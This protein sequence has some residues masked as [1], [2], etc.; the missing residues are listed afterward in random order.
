MD[1][2]HHWGEKQLWQTCECCGEDLSFRARFPMIKRE[3]RTVSGRSSPWS[4]VIMGQ[5]ALMVLFFTWPPVTLTYSGWAGGPPCSSSD[6]IN[7]S[8]PHPLTV[9]NHK[10]SEADAQYLLDILHLHRCRTQSIYDKLLFLLTLVA[11]V[12]KIPEQHLSA[13]RKSIPYTSRWNSIN[14]M[15][16]QLILWWNLTWKQALRLTIRTQQ[17]HSSDY[18][19]YVCFC[20]SYKDSSI[21]M[22]LFHYQIK[23]P[24]GSFKSLF[25][26]TYYRNT[27]VKESCFW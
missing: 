7:N 25:Y 14:F 12:D 5:R 19:W 8:T 10:L 15:T 3:V 24:C 27:E 20:Q 21:K 2:F 17:N 23:V 18:W 9:G 11:I 6:H 13:T 26:M 1:S 22:R 4:P 16:N